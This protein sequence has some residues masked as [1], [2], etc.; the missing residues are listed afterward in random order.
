MEPVELFI[1]YENLITYLTGP[2][3][4][5][6]ILSG[7][8]HT[9]DTFVPA[10]RGARHILLY[11]DTNADT[12]EDT[13]TK[14]AETKRKIPYHD[15]VVVLVDSNK[16]MTNYA[17]NSQD[18]RKLVV[19]ISPKSE[20]IFV[21]ED[22]LSTHVMRVRAQL[23]ESGYNI[24]D[25]HHS[26]FKIEMPKSPLVGEHKILT[27]TELEQFKSFYKKK[28]ETLPKIYDTDTQIIWINGNPG[29]VIRVTR[30]SEETETFSYRLC[31]R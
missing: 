19:K 18:F 30:Y 8:R 7:V 4:R 2:K 25:F 31:I 6:L 22:G 17:S 5:N 21:S 23:K 3:Y 26:T 14:N 12:N 9:I 20:I 10:L 13:D 28:L 24:R 27:G 11:A 16:D 29:D 15:V 1:I